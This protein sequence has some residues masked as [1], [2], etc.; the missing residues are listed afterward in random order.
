MTFREPAPT[1]PSPPSAELVLDRPVW[2]SLSG[3][4]QHLAVGDA[5]ARRYEP[6]VHL[7]ASAADDSPA[8]LQALG[9]LLPAEGALFVL[10]VPAIPIPPGAV[11]LKEAEGVQMVATRSLQ[12]VVQRTDI[13]ALGD[14]DAAEMLALAELT[15]PGPFLARTHTMG[16]FLGVRIAGRLAAMA[17]ERMHVEGYT[18]ISGVC[19]HPDFRGQ[20]LARQL[21]AAVAGQI[22]ARGERPFLHAWRSNAPAIA[23][24]EGL[25][26]AWR[27]PVHVAV[28]ARSS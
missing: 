10:Q 27:A 2:H 11:A 17:G 9:R 15:Q 3:P 13:Q 25:G 6:A 26:F 19:C 21:S 12:D 23:L 4:Q 5:L 7:F 22:E 28:M 1:M 24:Y 14:A 16:R 8:A 18:E 20:G